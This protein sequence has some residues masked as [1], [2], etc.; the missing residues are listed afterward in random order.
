VVQK[1]ALTPSP[2][3]EVVKILRRCAQEKGKHLLIKIFSGGMISPDVEDGRSVRKSDL[4]NECV[5]RRDGNCIPAAVAILLDKVSEVQTLLSDGDLIP[6]H[7]ESNHR[8]YEDVEQHLRVSFVAVPVALTSTFGWP[9]GD[10]LLH[11]E[12]AGMPHFVGLAVQDNGQ[13]IMSDARNTFELDTAT[14]DMAILNGIDKS[15]C[16]V[17]ELHA[18]EGVEAQQDIA[19]KGTLRKLLSLQGSNDAD[20]D[21]VEAMTTV[22]F[23]RFGQVIWDE[24]LVARRPPY[25]LVAMMVVR[26]FDTNDIV[27]ANFS[28]FGHHHR[29]RLMWIPKRVFPGVQPEN[30]DEDVHL[31]PNMSDESSAMLQA[32]RSRLGSQWQDMHGGSLSQSSFNAPVGAALTCWTVE[33]LQTPLDMEAGASAAVCHPMEV[34]SEDEVPESVHSS[35]SEA[36]TVLHESWLDAHARVLTDR[37][38]MES[39][40]QEVE[41]FLAAGAGFC[42]QRHVKPAL[43]HQRNSIDKHLSLIF[44]ASRPF[45]ARRDAVATLAVRRVGDVHYTHCFAEKL[46]REILVNSG[47]VNA[48]WTRII[49]EASVAGSKLTNLLP[50]HSKSWWPIVEDVFDSRVCKKLSE[51]LLLECTSHSE[52][53]Y[54]SVDGTVKCTMPLR[55]QVRPG[56]KRRRVKEPPFLSPEE[57]IHTIVTVRGRSGAVVGF[58]PLLSEKAEHL[59]EA[60]TRNLPRKALEQVECLATDAPS[61]HLFSVLQEILPCLQALCLDPVHLAIKYEYGTGR[62]RTKGASTLRALLSKQVQCSMAKSKAECVLGCA[63]NNSV[64]SDRAQFIEALEAISAK[65]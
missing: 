18:D 33:V 1:L 57:A 2:P 31:V 40:K 25:P 47:K 61:P 20:A 60:F 42:F 44:A 62:H 48:V 32:H 21:K 43:S 19:D 30:P 58:W 27:T 59:Q 14:L 4:S 22:A 34:T 51:H 16:M 26:R 24:D 53:A 10:Y 3:E 65:E 28:V 55:G 17:F 63:E 29:H 64:W 38:L 46:F 41:E 5:L 7:A 15:L 54:L 23:L 6:D 52:F 56:G 9:A 39:M 8:S 12:N 35:A 49:L 50:S 45:Y 37:Q 11:S 36:E 13:V